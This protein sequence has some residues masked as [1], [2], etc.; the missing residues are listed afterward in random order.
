MPKHKRAHTVAIVVSCIHLPF[1]LKPAWKLFLQAVDII[2]PDLLVVNGDG[3]D[4]AGI[5]PKNKV[6]RDEVLFETQEL[7]PTRIYIDELEAAIPTKCDT[8]WLEGNHERFWYRYH[9]EQAA[10][11]E[12]TWHEELGLDT[13]WQVLEHNREEMPSLTLGDLTVTHGAKVRAHSGW[14]AKAELLDR[15]NPVL[16]GHTHRMGAFYFTPS[17]T[18]V[19]FD[20]YEIGCLADQTTARKYMRKKPNWQIG[21]AV[22]SFDQKSG[23]FDV[24]LKKISRMRDAPTY[25]LGL[26]E[27]ILAATA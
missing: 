19:V 10:T 21:F 13:R 16:I 27:G 20:A 26:H 22:V 8:I 14:T 6:K 4:F 24:S 25:R 12:P 23:W 1:V 17:E 5:H 3:C 18:G 7:I 2:R 15:W 9:L 11:T